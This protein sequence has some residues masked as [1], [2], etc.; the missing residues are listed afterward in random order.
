MLELW[1]ANQA[2]GDIFCLQAF[3]QNV[4]ADEIG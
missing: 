4:L 1:N 3:V 2:R